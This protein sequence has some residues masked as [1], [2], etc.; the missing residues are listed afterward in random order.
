MVPQCNILCGISPALS[1]CHF[2]SSTA[3]SRMKYLWIIFKHDHIVSWRT[4]SHE[5]IILKGKGFLLAIYSTKY[6]KLY[7]SIPFYTSICSSST[8]WSILINI[9]WPKSIQ[10][11]LKPN[12]INQ[13]SKVDTPSLSGSPADYAKGCYRKEYGTFKVKDRAHFISSNHLSSQKSK[14]FV[15]HSITC[16]QSCCKWSLIGVKN[17]KWRARDCGDSISISAYQHRF[18]EKNASGQANFPCR[19]RLENYVSF[20]TLMSLNSC[21][22]A[23]KTKMSLNQWCTIQLHTVICEW[24]RD[25][26]EWPPCYVRPLK[27][28]CTHTV[29]RNTSIG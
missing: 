23:V 28:T 14:T 2:L 8:N 19:I 26:H 24:E 20:S 4:S 1:K 3:K 18:G 22:L 29:C 27:G 25:V 21:G 7:K 10:K 6:I 17:M 16:K 11:L 12:Q 13:K 5:L 15:V 9:G